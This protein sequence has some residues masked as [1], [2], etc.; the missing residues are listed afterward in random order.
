MTAKEAKNLTVS[1]IDQS[2]SKIFDLI[3]EAATSDMSFNKSKITYFV[4]NYCELS[5]D[6]K[7]RLSELGYD[8]TF[9][10]NEDFSDGPYYE[11]SW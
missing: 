3:R 10:L 7:R 9:D 6:Q 5:E 4:S 2:L 8:V 11:I 1:S